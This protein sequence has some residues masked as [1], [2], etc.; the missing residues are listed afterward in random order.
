MK[1][2]SDRKRAI[3][4]PS[5]KINCSRVIVRD[6]IRRRIGFVEFS[7][8]VRIPPSPSTLIVGRSFGRCWRWHLKEQLK[9]ATEIKQRDTRVLNEAPLDRSQRRKLESSNV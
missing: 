1:A 5:I 9:V 7:R 4:L 8:R 3:L 6:G 2:L